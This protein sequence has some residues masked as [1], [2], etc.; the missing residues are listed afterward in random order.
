MALRGASSR[1]ARSRCFDSSEFS[2]GGVG[3]RNYVN[4]VFVEFRD[5]FGARRRDGARPLRGS[6][7][8]GESAT[9]RYLQVNVVG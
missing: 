9:M 7:A 4:E 2:S 6:G 3:S 1:H 8:L 5:R